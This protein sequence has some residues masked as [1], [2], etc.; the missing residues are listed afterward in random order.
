MDR[1]EFLQQSFYG[2][3]VLVAGS[4]MSACLGGCSSESTTGPANVDFTL[5]LT[6]SAN[7]ALL[8]VGGYVR[9]NG[10]IVACVGDKQYVAVQ[11]NCTHEGGTLVWQQGSNR[12]YCGE[13]GATFARTGSVTNGP[14][15]TALAS[16]KTSLSGTSLRVYS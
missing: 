1:K 5:D 14:A 2:L 15:K 16:Y 9:I 13:H 11:Q 7:A 4:A 3:T 8:N 10:V 12:F 6:Q